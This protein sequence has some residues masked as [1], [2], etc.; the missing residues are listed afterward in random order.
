MWLLDKEDREYEKQ[1]HECT[2][3]PNLFLK[4]NE[5]IKKSYNNS[6]D[7]VSRLYDY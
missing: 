6:S 3:Q 2:F 5:S 1:K 7:V 4:R